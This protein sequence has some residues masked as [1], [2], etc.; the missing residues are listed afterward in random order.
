MPEYFQSRCLVLLVED[1]ALVAMN[2]QGELEE[3]GYAVVG[4]FDTCADALTWLENETP[5]LAVLDTWLQDGSCQVLA[6][7]L[8][9]RGI[10][11][12]VYSGL[13]DT[14]MAELAGAPWVSKPAPGEALL[15]ALT[16]AT[17]LEYSAA[18]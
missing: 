1:E 9:Q 14:Q 4:P 12:V 6:S 16:S 18:A 10:P 17:A 15:A 11:F 13:V 2:L 3:A 7:E 8:R 5:N